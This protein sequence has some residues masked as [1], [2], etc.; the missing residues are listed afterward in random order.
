MVP[1]RT[2]RVI[3]RIA[4]AS[5]PSRSTTTGRF[6]IASRSRIPTWGW[7]MIGVASTAPNWPGLVIVNVPPW[8]S[9]GSS[10]PARA[11]SATSAIPAILQAEALGLADHRDDQALLEGDRDPEVDLLLVDD[12]IAVQPRVQD[13]M[14][15]VPSTGPGDER[16]VGEQDIATSPP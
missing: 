14:A 8:T 6:T 9:S 7:L 4:I 2:G 10:P 16:Q 1:G 13:R 3:G 15:L 12:L 11:R 5:W